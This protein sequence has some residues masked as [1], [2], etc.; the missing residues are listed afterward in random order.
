[1]HP[2]HFSTDNKAIGLPNEALGMPSARVAE[3]AGN[4]QSCFSFE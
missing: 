3:M 1:M 4:S 2:A